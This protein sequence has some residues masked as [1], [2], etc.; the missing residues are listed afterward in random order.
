MKNEDRRIDLTDNEVKFI[1]S[2]KGINL[3]YNCQAAITDDGMI[4][5]GH[6]SNT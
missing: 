5:G 3:N 2:R 6:T 4:V 1:R